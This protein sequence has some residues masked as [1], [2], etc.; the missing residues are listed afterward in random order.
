MRLSF[1]TQLLLVG[2]T[3]LALRVAYALLD[4]E[5]PGITG[6]ADWYHEMANL[7]AGGKG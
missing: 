7:L 4:A 6:D 2:L 1:R 5:P 3:A